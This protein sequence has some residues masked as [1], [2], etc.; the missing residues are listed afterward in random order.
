MND[1]SELGYDKYYVNLFVIKLNNRIERIVT[2]GSQNI[3]GAD[4]SLYNSSIWRDPILGLCFSVQ[5]DD[6]KEPPSRRIKG[7]GTFWN[8]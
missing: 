4:Y 6:W 1:P 8:V 3:N 5:F 7:P 2:A